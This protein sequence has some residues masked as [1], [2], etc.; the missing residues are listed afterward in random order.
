MLAVLKPLVTAMCLGSGASGGLFT[1]TLC[2]G[3]LLGAALGGAWS[4]LWPGTPVGTFALVGAAAMIGAGMQALLAGLVLVLELTGTG[5]AIA[6]P[7]VVATLVA[8]A[9]A[10]WLDG[11]SIYSARLA[12]QP[13][14][15]QST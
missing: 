8:T 9:V 11:Y 10:R 5:F 4:A 13:T 3:A 14:A 12:A 15:E 6:V 2:T 1:P 7:L